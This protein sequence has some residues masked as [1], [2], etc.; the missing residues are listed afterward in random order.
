MTIRYS[1][2]P[3]DLHAHQFEVT[4]AFIASESSDQIFALPNWIPGSYMVRDFAKHIMQISAT[5][6]G[7]AQPLRKLDKHRW[8]LAL[9]QGAEVKL[10][11]RIYAYDD[12]IRAA[13][14]DQQRGFFN[15]TSLCLYIEGRQR[16]AVELTLVAPKMVS[17]WQVATGMPRLATDS[18][19]FG[20]YHA[21]DYFELID[22]PFA[23]GP[24]EWISFEACG[25]PH[26]MA[27]LG[28]QYAHKGRLARDLKQLCEWHIQRFEDQAP[29]DSYLFMV[30]V[31]GRGFGGLEHLNSTALVCSRKELPS[32]EGDRVSADY[33]TFLALCSHEYFHSWNVK[34]LKPALFDPPELSKENHTEQLW[35]YEGITSYYDEL[36]LLRCGLIDRQAYLQMLAEGLTR[37]YRAR[38]RK[39]QSVAESSFDA[40]TKL[41]SP[42]ANTPNAMVSYYTK[43]AMIALWLD[44]NLRKHSAGQ[45]SLDT[46]INHLWQHWGKV[47]R[48][49][50]DDSFVEAALAATGIDI[51]PWLEPALYG[52]DDLPLPELMADFGIALTL[53]P[54]LSA[55]DRGGVIN[56]NRPKAGLDATYLPHPRGLEIVQ[57][58]NGGAAEQAGL[59]GGDILI[60]L[61]QIQVAADNISY[62]LAQQH[63][64]SVSIH[65]FRKDQLISA[66]LP[67]C[68]PQ[69]DTC[70]LGV[71]DP[72]LAFDWLD[73]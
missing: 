6:D 10:C 45:Y 7:I 9:T 24:I 51:T 29:F 71:T 58:Y 70:E 25:I 4:L 72:E 14:L 23:L 69:I 48:G 21:D 44:L 38:G 26:R 27:L 13:Y 73:R 35:W 16:E 54:S 20:R 61:D 15:N 63:A 37:V 62:L 3:A 50:D 18:N 28:K 52:T 30:Q 40:W 19:G 12:S 53:R 59:S 39:L 55:D 67:I 8:Q 36:A 41:Y 2:V 17:H 60:A 42:N 49:T 33:R 66:D 34:R 46:I 57:V 65:F 43:G 64:A 56:S 5:V 68:R 47:G 1:V 31:E 22:Y 11:Y 32:D